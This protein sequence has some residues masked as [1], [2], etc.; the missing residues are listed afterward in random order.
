MAFVAVTLDGKPLVDSL[1][2]NWFRQSDLKHVGAHKNSGREVSIKSFFYLWRAVS[3][4]QAR[5]HRDT[6]R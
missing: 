5:V 4:Q 1:Q 2:G 6:C 3:I